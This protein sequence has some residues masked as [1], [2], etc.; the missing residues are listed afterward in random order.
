MEPLTGRI[1]RDQNRVPV[2]AGVSSVDGLTVLPAEI[3]PT[4]GRLLVDTA[5]SSGGLPTSGF[6]N[7]VTVGTT[8]VQ[9][10]SNVLT[11]GVIVQAL[12]TNSV[13][14]YLGFSNTVTTSTGSELVA[15]QATSVAVSNTN[16][17][18]AISGSA[19]QKLCFIGS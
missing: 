11:Q 7:Q 6:S 1:P 16:A 18:W 15:G 3:N 12:S 9:L 2:I 10:P 5:T 19:S 17:I 13:S 8:A 4:T 14:I